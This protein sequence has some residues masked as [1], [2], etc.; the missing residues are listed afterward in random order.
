MSATIEKTQTL[1][2]LE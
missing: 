1:L 2:K